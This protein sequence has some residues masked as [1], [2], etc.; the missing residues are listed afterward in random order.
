MR[1]RPHPQCRA[2]LGLCLALFA[3]AAC[4]KNTDKQAAADSVS[5]ASTTAAVDTTA[6]KSL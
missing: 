2:T 3:G 6:N 1:N 5:A 4:S